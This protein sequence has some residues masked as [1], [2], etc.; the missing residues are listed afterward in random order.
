MGE[1]D[2]FLNVGIFLF[3]FLVGL[4]EIDLPSLRRRSAAGSSSPRWCPVFIS[5]VVAL[6]V[7]SDL[8]HVDFSLDLDFTSALALS[9][10]PVAL[11]PGGW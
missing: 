9:G 3:F 11:Q 6:C 1:L 7:T 4:D 8:F 2:L 10:D 5:M